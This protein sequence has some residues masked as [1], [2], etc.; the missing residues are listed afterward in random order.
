[1]QERRKTQNIKTYAV[2]ETQEKRE[3]AKSTKNARKT[4]ETRN[5]GNTEKKNKREKQEIAKSTE[6]ARK[7]RRNKDCLTCRL[8]GQAHKNN[9]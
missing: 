9:L 1:M 5:A 3:I 6:N 4:G 7:N 2:Q 8:T